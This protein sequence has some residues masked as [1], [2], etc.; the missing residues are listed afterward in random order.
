ME[1]S[2]TKIPLA[3]G[4]IGRKAGSIHGQIEVSL[5]NRSNINIAIWR[6]AF[7][8]LPDVEFSVADADLED[9]IQILEEAR[10]KVDTFYYVSRI[11]LKR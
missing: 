1:E 6:K 9:I 5:S 2:K 4:L 10:R 7:C 8:G 3:S 11:P